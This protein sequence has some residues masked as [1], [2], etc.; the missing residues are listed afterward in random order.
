MVRLFFPNGV[1]METRANT[2]LE[3]VI[4]TVF[5]GIGTLC[6]ILL[7]AQLPA[8]GEK[9]PEWIAALG[10]IAAF[11]GTIWIATSERRQRILVERDR[12]TLAAADVY[13]R[14]DI[15]HRVVCDVAERVGTD[16]ALQPVTAVAVHRL[17]G[18][19]SLWEQAEILPLIG[20][21]GHV[22]TRLQRV[23]V[24]HRRMQAWLKE[25]STPGAGTDVKSLQEN[26]RGDLKKCVDD[27]S[28][29]RS[30]IRVLLHHIY[31]PQE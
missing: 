7:I 1:S 2:L 29:S 3:Y 23:L 19:L 13:D 24:R 9:R 11:A 30:E 10:T 18:Q 12:A 25:L 22:A 17:M 20:L 28:R 27:L 16:G 21:P 26:V 8:W 15:C 14:V 5:I 4:I 6:A 31:A